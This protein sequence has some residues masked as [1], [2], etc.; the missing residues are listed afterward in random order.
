MQEFLSARL[1]E[2]LNRT[3]LSGSPFPDVSMT[4]LAAQIESR[5]RCRDKLPTW[6]LKNGLLYP[7]RISIEQASSERTAAYKASVVTGRTLADLSG[8]FGVDSFYFSKTMEQVTWCE[9]D[10]D[11]YE[12]AS[13]NF[14]R[15]GANNIG[16]YQGDSMEFLRNSEEEYDWIF[17]DPARRNADSGRVF[18]LEDC[19]PNVLDNLEL[20]LTRAGRVMLKL[21]PFLDISQAVRQLRKVEEVHVVAVDNEVKEVLFLLSESGRERIPIHAVNLT[22]AGKQ[23]MSSIIGDEVPASTYGSPLKYLYEPNAAVL[24]A[25]LFNEVSAT[26]GL[27]KLH[28][29]SHLYTSDALIPF[30]GRSFEILS[31]NRYKAKTLRNL[32]GLKKA[33]ITIRNFHES[34]AQVRKRTGI[35]EGGEDYLF[36]TTDQHGQAL[37]LRC[38]KADDARHLH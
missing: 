33:N 27:T 18:R 35:A 8:G 16:C 17:V 34:V 29:N 26:Y 13:H 10:P 12:V 14:R 37:V 36:F 7:P 23:I 19:S 30:P 15:L 32:L 9:Q 2:D 1:E 38:R 4:E 25:G 31:S 28:P 22:A 11:L 3:I 20:F 6:Y 21:S 5:R 24:K